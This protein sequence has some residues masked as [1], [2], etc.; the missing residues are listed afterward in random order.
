MNEFDDELE[1]STTP[2]SLEENSETSDND[3]AASAVSAG[4]ALA[5][6]ENT[7]AENADGDAEA[8]EPSKPFSDILDWVACIIYAVV[9][10][11]V[12]NLFFLRL[13]TV[14]G[15]SMND[16][17]LNNDRVVVSNFFY[18]PKYEDIVVVQADKIRQ[19]G[20]G[21]Y[22]EPIIKR[23]IAVEGD[24]V[25]I[26]YEKGEVYR[27]GELLSEDYIKELTHQHLYGYMENGQDYVVPENCVFVMGDNRNASND[28]R[29][30]IDVGFV[31]RS[32]IMGKALVR[33]IPIKN[34]EW[35]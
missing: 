8:E 28:S 32:M 12:L 2:E 13:T 7:A 9:L 11:L 15:D 4:D 26:D 33:V 3:Q 19:T 1:E 6:S 35:L 31:D 24:T 5:D 27:N 14:S 25:R 18:K 10:I 21:F 22:G 34:F 23:V 30:L 17:L 16:T 29:N 20:T